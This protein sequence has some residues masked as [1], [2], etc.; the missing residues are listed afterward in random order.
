MK[1]SEVKTKFIQAG[2]H[3]FAYRESGAGF[4]LVLFQRF[5]GTM[6]EWDPA[7][8]DH[9]ARKNRVI[10]FDNAGVGATTGKTPNNIVEMAKD[11]FS[12]THALGLKKF[13]IGGWSLGGIVAQVFA[14]NY[15]RYVR[16]IILI[17]TGPG[18]SAETVY[19]HERFLK[20]AHHDENSVEDQQIL[21]FTETPD[22]LQHTLNSLARISERTVDIS[23]VTKKEN[24]MNQAL[25]MRDFF[26]GPVDY[27]SKLKEIKHP[28]L[29]GAAKH[30]L[31]FPLIDAYLLT[32]EIQNATLIAYPN[33]G[34]GFHHQ[35][36]QHFATVVNG[37][38]KT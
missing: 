12:F 19:P 7:F 10:I 26:S 27:F 17:G 5:R 4:P 8:I 13:N 6:D 30:D 35:Y 21:F 22:G 14:L 25:A 2:N 23:P 28:V 1:A 31:A 3:R 38:L 33:A 11:G 18:R 36:H 34:H 20:I 16:K 37:F 32:Q 24:W 29:I 15:P 9:L